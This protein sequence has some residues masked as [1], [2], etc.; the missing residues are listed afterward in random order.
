M[1]TPDYKIWTCKIGGVVN[2]LPPGADSPM[3][4]AV[5][6]GFKYVTHS[7]ALFI[8]SGWAG[9]LTENELSVIENRIPVDH[10]RAE[11]EKWC[12]VRWGVHAPLHMSSTSGEWE[13]WQAA[14]VLYEGK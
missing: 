3:R 12:L 4:Y 11:F 10:T 7:D 5:R 2:K 14:R 6:A 1:K 8:F 13:A 9:S